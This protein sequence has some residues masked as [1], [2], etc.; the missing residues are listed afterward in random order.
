[1]NESTDIPARA[2][3]YGAALIEDDGTETPITEE[4]IAQ[5]CRELEGNTAATGRW[6]ELCAHPGQRANQVGT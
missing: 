1:M 5:A 3:F 4:M 6:P 2:N